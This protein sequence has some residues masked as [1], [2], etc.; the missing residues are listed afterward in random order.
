MARTRG[1]TPA[2]KLQRRRQ[3]LSHFL[4]GVTDSEELSRRLHCS[5]RTI[6]LDLEALKPW[7]YR[8]V[9]TEQL[10]S[11]RIAF[12]QKQEIWREIWSELDSNE[13]GE[14]KTSDASRKIRYLELAIKMSAE[15]DRLCGIAQPQPSNSH[16]LHTPR[17]NVPITSAAAEEVK[18]MSEEEQLIVAKNIRNHER[19]KASA[20]T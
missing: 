1:S 4:R 17:Q 3:L 14:K 13:E 10:H 7:L 6:Q 19:T 15:F 9:E 5:I 8:K 11:L 18:K 2:N 16:I 12:L 20:H